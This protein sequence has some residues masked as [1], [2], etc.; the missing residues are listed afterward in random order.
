M[1]TL[2]DNLQ[3]VTRRIHAAE[4]AASRESGSVQLIAVGKLHPA[5]AIRTL[6]E[7]GQRHFAENFVQEALTKQRVLN[8][9]DIDWHFIGRIQSN[10]TKDIANHF[11][12]VHSVDRLK[13]A[14]RL[15][16]QRPS[17]QPP[18]NLCLQLN[19][20]SEETKSGISESEL[21]GLIASIS[22]LPNIHIRGLMIVPRP[23]TDPARQQPVFARV[24]TLLKEANSKGYELDTLSMGMTSDLEYAIAEGS[25]QVRIGTALFGHRPSKTEVDQREV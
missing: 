4:R 19:L 14:R 23:E 6:Y 9:L 5:Q 20:Q 1:S 10:K 24:R 15:S 12:W 13:I 3:S 21:P 18:L 17:T 16:D 22:E 8:D 11:S 25:T 2:K 7:A